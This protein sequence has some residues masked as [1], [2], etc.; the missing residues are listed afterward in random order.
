M[1]ALIP[2]PAFVYGRE[3]ADITEAP[4]EQT[5]V[6]EQVTEALPQPE[7]F[8]PHADEFIML[9]EATGETVTM[10]MEEYIIGSVLAEMPASFEEEA[11][12]A[13][14]VAVHT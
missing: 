6:S 13:Q 5:T 4:A 12:K 10:S 14:A 11:I 8:I 9:C 2:L 7:S 1:T 3:D